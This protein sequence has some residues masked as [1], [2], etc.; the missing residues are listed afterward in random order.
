M[1]NASKEILNFYS[2]ELSL[3]T[4]PLIII[5]IYLN[6]I[7][8]FFF[9]YRIEGSIEL[10]PGEWIISAKAKNTEG[11]AQAESIMHTV[12]IPDGE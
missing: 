11:W 3:L 4:N 10:Q 7:F 8:N 12:K 5:Y 2:L 6:N 9:L 1:V